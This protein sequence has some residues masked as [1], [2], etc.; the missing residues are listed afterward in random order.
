MTIRTWEFLSYKTKKSNKFIQKANI[1]HFCNSCRCVDWQT[2]SAPKSIMW[3][4]RFWC[5]ALVECPQILATAMKAIGIFLKC[6]ST[7]TTLNWKT[8]SN[9]DSVSRGK[10]LIMEH[11]P[12]AEMLVVNYHLLWIFY[13]SLSNLGSADLKES[14]RFSPTVWETCSSTC[15]GKKQTPIFSWLHNW[16]FKPQLFTRQ[17]LNCVLKITGRP[18]YVRWGWKDKACSRENNASIHQVQLRG[19]D[20]KL[21]QQDE[22]SSSSLGIFFLSLSYYFFLPRWKRQPYYQ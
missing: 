4:K 18:R 21:R 20:I 16:Q 9:P 13:Y 17:V 14:Y 5:L 8:F 19:R 22:W 12:S 15:R 7:F 3:I 10:T 1:W 11:P 6:N 2:I